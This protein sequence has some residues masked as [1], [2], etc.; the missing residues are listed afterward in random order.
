MAIMD[1]GCPYATLAD[2]LVRCGG[3]TGGSAWR[4]TCQTLCPATASGT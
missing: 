3:L 2:E 1:A 4:P